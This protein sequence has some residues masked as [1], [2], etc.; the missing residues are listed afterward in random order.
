MSSFKKISNS[1]SKIPRYAGISCALNVRTSR[2]CAD[3]RRLRS[4]M[5]ALS[6]PAPDAGSN[7]TQRSSGPVQ[8]RR[9]TIQRA[10]TRGDM[11]RGKAYRKPRS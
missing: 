8:R 9:Q 3:L 2:P 4:R 1:I 7:R 6:F 5:G 11:S 10:V